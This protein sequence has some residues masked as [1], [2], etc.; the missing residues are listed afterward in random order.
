MWKA[1][2]NPQETIIYHTRGENMALLNHMTIKVS[3]GNNEGLSNGFWGKWFRNLK[4]LLM[5]L[6]GYVTLEDGETE[7]WKI[8]SYKFIQ[9]VNGAGSWV[10]FWF[11]S[12]S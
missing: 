2:L 5:L 9:L 10:S 3:T 12:P 4:K 6:S 11:Q 1:A 8:D 7:A